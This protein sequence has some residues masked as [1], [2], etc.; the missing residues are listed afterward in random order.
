[1]KRVLTCVVPFAMVTLLASMLSPPVVAANAPADRVVAM[2]FH[3]VPGCATC[4]KMG[5]YSAEAVQ[6]GFAKEIK[7][8][9]VQF[10]VID[11][12]NPKNAALTNGYKVTGPTLI[13]AR[14][15]GNKVK[16][17]KNL[18]EIW[19][20][21]GDKAAFLKYVRANVAAYQG[22]ESKTARR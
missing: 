5:G 18:T 8:G 19:S 4:Q 6:D 12:E 17:Y 10:Y 3:R 2:Y 1:M 13:V 11:F 22:P 9:K 15:V 21:V 16:Q 20:K 14:I 7:Q